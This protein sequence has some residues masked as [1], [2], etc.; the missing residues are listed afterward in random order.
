MANKTLITGFPRIGENREL[1]K[2]LE[3]YWS[4]ESKIDD[5][6]T[7]A[8]GLRK[9]HWLF[10]KEQSI[11]FIS[12]NDFSLYGTMLD[13]AVMLGA[14]PAR[15]LDIADKD[16]RYFAMARGTE[17]AA[18]MSMTKWFN[19]NYHYIVPELGVA[20]SFKLDASKILA[21]YAE[22]KTLGSMAK[23]M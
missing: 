23:S 10:Q 4:G 17:T 9:K 7:V 22:A 15:F 21:E 5:L 3:S 8:G 16:K 1:K 13:T 12:V 18:A 19:T 2:A 20:Q 6:K 14:I 11:D